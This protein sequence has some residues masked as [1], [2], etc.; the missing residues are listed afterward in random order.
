M[1]SVWPYFGRFEPISGARAVLRGTRRVDR[2]DDAV[3]SNCKNGACR[4]RVPEH[5]QCRHL[6][7]SEEDSVDVLP[8]VGADV[9]EFRLFR[10]GRGRASFMESRSNCL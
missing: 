6:Q 4:S 7:I 5:L 9:E 3:P 8:D 1:V 10:L 2:V